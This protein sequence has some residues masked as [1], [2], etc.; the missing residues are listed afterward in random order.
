MHTARPCALL[1][2][3]VLVLLTACSA[4]WARQTPVPPDTRVVVTYIGN[5]G[6]GLEALDG[7][8]GTPMWKTPVGIIN[9]SPPMIENGVVYAITLDHPGMA[10]HVVAVRE[11]DGK[12]LWRV[13]VPY[14]TIPFIT[15]DE[16]ILALL[17]FGRELDALDPATGAQRWHVAANLAGCVMRHGVIYASGDPTPVSSRTPAASNNTSPPAYVPQGLM[18]LNER[19]GSLVW[20]VREHV[21]FV[22]MAVTDRTIYGRGNPDGAMYA[23][24]AQSGRQLTDVSHTAEGTAGSTI[25]AWGQFLAATDR[26]VLLADY[27]SNPVHTRALSAVDGKV[28]WDVP[29]NF[30]NRAASAAGVHITDGFIYSTEG[31]DNITAVRVS[32]GS[33]AWKRRFG[34]DETIGVSVIGGVVFATLAPELPPPPFLCSDH[35]ASSVVALDAATGTV[36][37][38]HDVDGA[39]YLAVPAQ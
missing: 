34:T 1:M 5:G 11:R 28:L 37:W 15:V 9:H 10:P 17:I 29:V 30:L 14:D 16:S 36:L 18:A 24:D 33:V 23:F 31:P 21:A 12:L 8:T 38:Q 20:Q 7:T 27:Q 13:T 22:P 3:L 19:D 26:F 4:P 2:A 6:G 32:N 35:C 25:F 39:A